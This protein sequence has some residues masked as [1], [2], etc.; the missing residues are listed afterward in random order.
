MSR[1]HF[2]GAS[3]IAITAG[4]STAFAADMPQANYATPAPAYSPMS[5][6]S[7]TGPYVGLQGG[8]GWGTS[9]L[10]PGSFDTDGWLG[11]VYGGYNYQV[12][13]N[14]V[15][16]LE[17]DANLNGADGSNGVVKVENP[18]D[19]SL[20]VRGGFAADRFLIYGTGGL[21]FGEVKAKDAT[22]SDSAT[23]TGWTLGGGV[24]AAVTDHITTRVEYRYTDLGK[25]SYDLTT[26]TDIDSSGSRLTVGV[27][28]K[29]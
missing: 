17:G 28:F 4:A 6:F 26:P 21:A 13:P 9:D 1:I 25:D 20:R 10:N 24:E 7:W 11:G 23:R 14:W 16:G 27:G 5:A 2:L 22:Y 19:A 12:S 18:W 3:L 8:Y 15:L 29:F